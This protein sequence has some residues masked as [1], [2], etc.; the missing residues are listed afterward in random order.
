MIQMVVALRD[1]YS[2]SY[3]IGIV[4]D[5]SLSQVSLLCDLGSRDTSPTRFQIN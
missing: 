4:E 1:S 5:V 3:F 2:S